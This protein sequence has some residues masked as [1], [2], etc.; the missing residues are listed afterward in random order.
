ML[1]DGTYVKPENEKIMYGGMLGIRSGL[2]L[3]MSMALAS[4]VTIAIRYSLV[5]RQSELKP[6]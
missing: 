1:E 2:P 4:A 6:K 5:R 3:Q